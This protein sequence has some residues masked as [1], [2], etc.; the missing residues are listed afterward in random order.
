MWYMRA[1]EAKYLCV[2]AAKVGGSAGDQEPDNEAEEA[3]DGAEDF[4][5]KNLYE[6]VLT[7]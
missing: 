5:N 1:R 6:P 7:R 4:D 3:K 2:H